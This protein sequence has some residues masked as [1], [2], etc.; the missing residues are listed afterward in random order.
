MK[1]K[2][3][4]AVFLLV[5]VLVLAA[6][7]S[8]QPADAGYN[9]ARELIVLRKISHKLLLAAG[10]SSSPV[11]AIKQIS[12]TE[13]LLP[14]ESA[15]SFHPDSLVATINEVIKQHGLSHRYIVNVLQQPDSKVI[16]GYAMAGSEQE[17]II[18]CSG[19]KQPL[20]HYAVKIS[21]EPEKEKIAYYW[22]LAGLVVLL[23]V[24][25]WVFWRSTQA[26]SVKTE[27]PPPTEPVT[28]T[29]IPIG[30]YTFFAQ[31]QELHFGETIISLTGKETRLL[32]I[33]GSA[34]NQLIDRKRLQKEV[35]EDEGVIV[36]R[37]L[38][39][40]ISK[41]RKKL[42]MDPGVQL[43]NVHGKGYKLEVLS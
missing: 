38:D 28:Q 4:R 21:W 15:F 11:P 8:K 10:D 16:F 17:N 7:I 36:G 32:E 1:G 12:D 26:V 34:C 40:Y 30:Q 39:M 20:A 31:E 35:W 27:N 3:Y 13:F 14:F 5:P 41:L 33:F 37:S 18:P 19:R 25:G 2:Q 22:L 42:E 6:F 9:S 23:P 43:V 24:M 29:G